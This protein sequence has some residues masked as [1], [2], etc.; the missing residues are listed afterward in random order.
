MAFYS[1]TYI[2]VE[3]LMIKAC[4][5]VDAEERVVPNDFRLD[6]RLEYD[7]VRAINDDNLF[8]ALDYAEVV[9]TAKRVMAEPSMLLEHVVGRLRKALTL[10]M[11]QICGGRIRLAKLNP[12]IDA[13]LTSCAFVLE[14]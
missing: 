13:E 3:G 11:P 14:W 5:G 7:A 2:E 8:S 4:H 12:P 6:I 10:S 9:K 1:K